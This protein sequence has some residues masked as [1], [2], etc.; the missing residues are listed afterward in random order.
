MV[1]A[2]HSIALHAPDWI[3]QL[4][5]ELSQPNSGLLPYCVA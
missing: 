1:K 3:A 5:L 4:C 2:S